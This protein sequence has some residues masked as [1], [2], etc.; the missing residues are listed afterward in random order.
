TTIAS[1]SPTRMMSTPASSTML[2]PGASYAVIITSGSA[3]PLRARTAGTVNGWER[4]A[5]SVGAAVPV[6][7]MPCL[8]PSSAPSAAGGFESVAPWSRR[9]P[10]DPATQP[11]RRRAVRVGRRREVWGS[12]RHP[13]RLGPGGRWRRLVVLLGR[14]VA[15]AWHVP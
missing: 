7:D 1:E 8:L 12:R 11:L 4:D 2:A 6:A 9:R 15:H 14:C 13:V 3:E 5:P 10:G